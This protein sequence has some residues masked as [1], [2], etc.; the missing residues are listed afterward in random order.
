MS[1]GELG[2]EIR[3]AAKGQ[4]PKDFA[5]QRKNLD[6]ILLIMGSL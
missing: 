5:D 6:S 3:V 4:I 1:R 2:D